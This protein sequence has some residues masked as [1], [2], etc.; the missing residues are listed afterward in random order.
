MESK[1]W[2]IADFGLTSEATSSRLVTSRY[3]RGKPGYRAPELISEQS[4]YNNK[5]DMW[6]L[7]CITGELI[8]GVKTF[9]GDYAVIQYSMSS[10]AEP[11]S[12]DDV[13]SRDAKLLVEAFFVTSLLS[14][15][16]KKRPSAKQLG[17]LCQIPMFLLQ[18]GLSI[19][20]KGYT[21]E[22]A[23]EALF[24]TDRTDLASALVEAMFTSG[25][26]FNSTSPLLKS[27]RK[28][29]VSAASKHD[30]KLIRPLLKEINLISIA[31]DAIDKGEV[32]AVY[33]MLDSGADIG[34]CNRNGETLLHR[35]AFAGQFEVS[36]RL[37]DLGANVHAKV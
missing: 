17:I 16:P 30:M 20:E 35:A 27:V 8:T 26:C 34:E 3:G 29:L 1:S 9:S 19:S 31:F 21:A 7:G 28:M 15:D 10:T 24:R 6:A 11:C 25:I 4:G 5:T 13:R 18:S 37:L 2:K 32:E 23:L 22:T 14:R 36:K 12:L 33:F